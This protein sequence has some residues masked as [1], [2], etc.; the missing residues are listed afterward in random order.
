MRTPGVLTLTLSVIILLDLE[1]GIIGILDAAYLKIVLIGR[2][3]EILHF[4]ARCYF[5]MQVPPFVVIDLIDI[6]K[7]LKN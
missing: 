5:D 6:A 4:E 7:C 3:K 2:V 1:L